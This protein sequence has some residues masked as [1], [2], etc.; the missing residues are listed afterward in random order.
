LLQGLC[1]HTGQ[2]RTKHTQT[3]VLVVGFEPT[4]QAF[5]RTK[6]VRAL[7]VSTHSILTIRECDLHPEE[8][9]RFL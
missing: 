2:T 1:L 4:I 6:T 3:F 9:R 7:A 5:E 8:P